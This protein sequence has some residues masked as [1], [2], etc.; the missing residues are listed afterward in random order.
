MDDIEDKKL[1][2]DR[3]RS[4]REFEIREKELEIKATQLK[5]IA[6]ANKSRLFSSQSVA[7]IT[8]LAGIIGT[9]LGATVQGYFNLDLEKK[10][11]ESSLI[12][13]AIET[14]NNKQSAK[15]LNFLVSAGFINDPDN[16]ISNLIGSDETIPVLPTKEN[17]SGKT[18]A[19]LDRMA[20]L[21]PGLDDEKI[22]KI[23]KDLTLFGY[24]SGPIDAI[25]SGEVARALS[26]FRKDQ[27]FS[28]PIQMMSAIRRLHK[29]AEEKER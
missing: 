27:G 28:S 10:K 19:E 6:Q 11:M 25:Y 24:Y 5:E 2:F 4:N 1:E 15:N 9:F 16:K 20:R 3:W 12:I 7:M 13:Q 21:I 22:T 18:D 26:K 23:Q 17:R 29:L 14:G 8:I